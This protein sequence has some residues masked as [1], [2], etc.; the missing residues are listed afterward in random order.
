MRLLGDLVTA[1][2]WLALG[3]WPAAAQTVTTY[4]CGRVTA[5]TAP[6][7]ITPGS[8]TL[9]TSRFELAPGSAPERE[10]AV[11][12]ETCID[13]ERNAT[14][15]YTRVT[16]TPRALGVC[17]VVTAY[18]APTASAPGSITLTSAGG[19]YT[20]PVS[21]GVTL[22][23]AQVTGGQ[24]FGIGVNAQ[25]NAEVLR[26]IGVWDGPPRPSATPR[27]LPSTAVA[28]TDAVPRSDGNTYG[29]TLSVAAG[30]AAV[31]AIV[32]VGILAARF[33]RR[34]G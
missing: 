12:S 3:A 15:A 4:P 17:G 18:S 20:L 5:Y 9:G 22:L 1:V 31:A 16:L 2:L 24:C 32:A 14:G 21:A 23:Q 33:A 25:G 34:T 13:G 30:G 11:G 10:F 28:A 8:I 19:A 26:Y 29:P 7:A 6:T 27:G